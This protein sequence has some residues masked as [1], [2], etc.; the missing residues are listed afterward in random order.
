MRLYL[1]DELGY[2]PG[3]KMTMQVMA[4]AV[5]EGLGSK[6]VVTGYL[7]DNKNYLDEKEESIHSIAY[8]Y[9]SIY[10]K[11]RVLS[12]IRSFLKADVVKLGVSLGV[13]FSRTLSC[14]DER[15]G[16]LVHCG[17]CSPCRKRR[18]GFKDAGVKD[19][20]IYANG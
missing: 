19:P 2:I 15:F 17:Q 8:L 13:D 18:Q 6:L 16:G 7:H 11:I 1:N 9:S 5:A 3:Y 20:T 10:T 4:M 12:P 14:K